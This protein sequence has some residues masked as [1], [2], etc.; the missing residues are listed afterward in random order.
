MSKNPDWLGIEL[1]S[2]RYRVEAKLGEGGMGSVYRAWDHNLE[3]KVVIKVPLAGSMINEEFVRRF[4]QEV[5]ALVRLQHPH[6]V[7]VID[8]GKHQGLPFAVM[9]YLAGGSLR[10]R[11]PRGPK[12]QPLPMPIDSLSTWLPQVADAV[13]FIHKQGFIHRDIKPANILFDAFGNVYLGD[14]GLAKALAAMA[15]APV[16]GMTQQGI[17]LGTPDYMAPEVISGLNFDG[18]ADQYALAI[19]VYELLTAVSPFLGLNLRAILLKQ[20][21]EDMMPP[22]EINKA[23]PAALAVPLRRALSKDPEKRHANCGAFAKAVLAAVGAGAKAPQ[24]AAARVTSAQPI[25]AA[26][27]QSPSVIPFASTGRQDPATPPPT[28][29]LNQGNS[30]IQQRCPNCQ[31]LARFPAQAQ[32]RRVPCPKCKTPLIIGEGAADPLAAGTANGR[33]QAEGRAVGGLGGG[34]FGTGQQPP[35]VM[36]TGPAAGTTRAE[37]A[38]DTDT[39]PNTRTSTPPKRTKPWMI[40]GGAIFIGILLAVIGF[41]VA[42]EFLGGRGEDQAKK[43][44]AKSTASEPEKTADETPEKPA[45]PPDKTPPAAPEKTP[46]KVPE[47]N[48]GGANPA[49]APPMPAPSKTPDAGGAGT[50]A[51]AGGMP[52]TAPNPMP[53]PPGGAKPMP[54]AAPS[55]PV[56]VKQVFAL[57][58]LSPQQ[59]VAADLKSL[60][61]AGAKPYTL[62]LK[63]LDVQLPKGIGTPRQTFQEK[64]GTLKVALE[65]SGGALADLGTFTIKDDKLSFVWAN[66]VSDA[67]GKPG[68]LAVRDCVLEVKA[69]M[70][71][72]TLLALRAVETVKGPAFTVPAVTTERTDYPLDSAKVTWPNLP[73]R[74]LFIE[75][76][77]KRKPTLKNDKTDVPIQSVTVAADKIEA[78]VDAARMDAVVHKGKAATYKFEKVILTRE[79]SSKDNKVLAQLHLVLDTKLPK[80]K[81]LA[82]ERARCEAEAKEKEPE[83]NREKAR[84]IMFNDRAKLAE[85][86]QKYDDA[87]KKDTELQT[88]QKAWKDDDAGLRA[89]VKPVFNLPA[90]SVFMDVEGLRV[91]VYRFDGK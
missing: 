22:H 51:V 59:Q 58:Q 18:K 81:E 56:L 83:Y 1:A 68:A 52:P 33:T 55:G 14:F 86:K 41:L 34:T 2:G 74:A 11:I 73:S 16:P 10:D 21:A 79:I 57:P 48:G 50:P 29:T 46:A 19:T 3:D 84:A 91:E 39:A 27:A 60:N 17:V 49:P 32:G 38:V 54:P 36:P 47:P 13:D 20:Q 7:R 37:Q 65:R 23:L 66:I 61:I 82:E 8:V 15:A 25:P 45:P 69:A 77:D 63:G 71:E 88:Q 87:K 90:G 53:P 67:T 44:D 76:D 75:I 89:K 30:S 64:D 5:R 43:V 28:P 80:P 4:E 62:T 31:K 40:F 85:L 6:V 70:G 78:V 35:Q 12:G 24:T 42:Q 26:P 72:T 9:Q